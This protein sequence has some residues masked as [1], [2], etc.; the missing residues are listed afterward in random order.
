MKREQRLIIFIHLNDFIFWGRVGPME[1]RP[2]ADREVRGSNSTLANVN[3]S[4]H[5]KGISEAPLDQVVNWYP[6]RAESVQV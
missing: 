3:Y 5:K 2:T 6:E 1:A 4:G